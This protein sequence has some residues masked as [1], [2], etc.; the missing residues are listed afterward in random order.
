MANGKGLDVP[1][2]T[3]FIEMRFRISIGETNEFSFS[4]SFLFPLC[5]DGDAV[6]L[7]GCG[8]ALFD[9]TYAFHR[10]T[11]QSMEFMLSGN[12]VPKFLLFYFS[13]FANKSRKTFLLFFAAFIRVW[14]VDIWSHGH[15][16][17][18]SLCSFP[19]CHFWSCNYRNGTFIIFSS[20]IIITLLHLRNSE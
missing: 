13:R 17:R 16:Y 8:F 20:I 14:R 11:I 5:L 12:Q 7:N 19:N 9:P 2:R 10:R 3:S 6:L 15:L 18:A 1:N 4:L